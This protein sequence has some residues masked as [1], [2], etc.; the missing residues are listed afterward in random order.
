MDHLQDAKDE[1]EVRAKEE[2][3]GAQVLAGRAGGRV[4]TTMALSKGQSSQDTS[5]S[6]AI[7][8]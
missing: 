8:S 4:E 3:D 7:T 5:L 1:P 6:R 2:L